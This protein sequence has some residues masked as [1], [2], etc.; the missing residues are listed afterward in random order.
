M[1]TAHP[2]GVHDVGGQSADAVVRDEHDHA[3]WE[4]RVD[5]MMMLLS[6]RKML[7]VDELRRNIEALR[8]P[9]TVVWQPGMGH[10]EG[11]WEQTEDY[12]AALR[13]FVGELL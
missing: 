9:T 2:V 12:H 4:R 3:L 6:A 8:G 13:K 5:A 10:A 1:G 7:V 11:R